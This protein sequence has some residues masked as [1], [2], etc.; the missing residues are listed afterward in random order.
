MHELFPILSGLIVGLF[1]G[2]VRSSVRAPVAV[3]L[4]VVLGALATIVTGEYRI[5]W[6]F[7]LID[8]TLVGV[9]AAIAFFGARRIT[10][11]AR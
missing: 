6:G 4:A 2:T 1:V 5:S 10:H 3:A 9:S 8:V 11:V 7:L